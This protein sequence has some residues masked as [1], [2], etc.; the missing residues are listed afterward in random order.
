MRQT[1]HRP[2][3]FLLELII[4]LFLFAVC[5]AVCIGLLL[6]ARGMSVE[7]GRLTQAVYAAESMAESWRATGAQP[8]WCVPDEYN[9]VGS[10]REHD[11]VAD[12][13]ITDADD[14]AVV[15]SLEGVTR[16]GG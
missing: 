13:T 6:H 5:A 10:L 16:I 2:S 12:I 3:L 1:E 8:M 15:F 11:G 4:D 14:G 7:S 9:L